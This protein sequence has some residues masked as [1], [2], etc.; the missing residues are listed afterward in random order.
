MK[1]G[2]CGQELV[3]DARMRVGVDRSGDLCPRC[4]GRRILRGHEWG[5]VWRGG[6]FVGSARNEMGS[7]V[8]STWCCSLVLTF[9]SHSTLTSPPCTSLRLSSPPS[10]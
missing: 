3:G 5:V 9:V 10:H 7:I 4:G 2:G 6:N 1:E 8:T